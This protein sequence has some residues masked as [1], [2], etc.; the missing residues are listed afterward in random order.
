MLRAHKAV[1]VHVDEPHRGADHVGELLSEA[2][3]ERGL[4]GARWTVEEQQTVERRG[5]ERELATDSERQG[6]V[7]EQSILDVGGRDDRVPQSPR[8]Q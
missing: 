1:R 7:A 4:T 5:R 6:G 2:A 3:S 8:A